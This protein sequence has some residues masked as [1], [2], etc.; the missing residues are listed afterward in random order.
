[1]LEMLLSDRSRCSIAFAPESATMF[2]RP[3][4]L[5]FRSDRS[6]SVPI[7]SSVCAET[8]EPERS[9]F[10]RYGISIRKV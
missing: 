4:P 3:Q 2:E 8:R 7:Y 6:V 1:M 5:R 10:S 9:S